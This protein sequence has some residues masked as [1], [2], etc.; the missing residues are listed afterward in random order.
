MDP[1]QEHSRRVIAPANRAVHQDQ[2]SGLQQRGVRS[3]GCDAPH[4]ARARD[5]GFG[6]RVV[7]LAGVDL[8]RV[9]EHVGGED[10]DDG[11]A[12]ARVWRW[13]CLDGWGEE[14]EV[15]MR[16]RWVSGRVLWAMMFAW[17]AV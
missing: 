9:G 12:G 15:R 5:Q 1:A 14:V 17:I 16:A 4:G 13:D 6:E 3:H 11:A 7:A 10:A 8:A 2:Q